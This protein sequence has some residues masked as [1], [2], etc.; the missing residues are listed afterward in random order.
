[1]LAKISDGRLAPR[2]PT[3]VSL[4]AALAMFWARLGSLNA[5]ETVSSARFWRKW[6]GRRPCSVDTVGRVHARLHCNELRAGLHH[7]Y[8]RLKRNKAL[9]LNLGRDVAVLDG[10]ESHASYRRHCRGCLRR[11]VSSDRGERVHF[12]HRHVTLMLLPGALPGRAP[13]RLLLDEEPQRPEEDEVATAVRLLRRVL[14]AYP[15]A[16]DLL[17]ADGL[18]A[19]APF[20]NFLLDHGKHILVVLKDERRNLYQDVQGL[21]PLVPPQT[22]RYRQRECLWWDFAQLVSWPQVQVPL[23]VIRS[24]E[25]HVVRSQLSRQLVPQTSDWICVTTLPATQLDTER[26]V[27]MG[28]QRWDIEN[29]GF[30]ELVNEWAAD[31]VYKHDPGAMEAFL[32][33]AFLA[34]NIF[35]AF[36]RLNLKPQIRRC[37]PVIFWARCLAAEVYLDVGGTRL[38]SPP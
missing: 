7:V 14:A 25:T 6:L 17:L 21:F 29:P 5:L 3:A 30:N 37:R 8:E 11:I 13:L 28:H 24:L 23:R 36:I 12:Y 22:G 34:Y 16:F 35:H 26:A 20:F 10:H 2:I 31:H 32:L 15:R 4:K 19:T 27:A 33:M 18:Y 9:P 38:R 1:M